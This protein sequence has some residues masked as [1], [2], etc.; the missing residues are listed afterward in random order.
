MKGCH[1]DGWDD[2]VGIGLVDERVILWMLMCRC[3][4]F[5]L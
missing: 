3:K 5:C 4:R 2:L 1:C